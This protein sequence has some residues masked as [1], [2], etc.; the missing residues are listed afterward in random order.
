MDWSPSS[1]SQPHCEVRVQ[2]QGAKSPCG[3]AAAAAAA[4]Q[5]EEKMF[6]L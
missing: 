2:N 6:Q 3:S 5:E 4:P 1:V